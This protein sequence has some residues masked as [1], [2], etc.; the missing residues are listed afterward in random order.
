VMPTEFLG[1]PVDSVPVQGSI[2]YVMYG[3]DTQEVLD[4]LS[5]EL[6]THVGEGRKLIEGTLDLSRLIAHV[7]DYEDDFSWIKLTVDLSGTEQHI[8]DPLSPTGA[9]F[10]K[11]VRANIKG[12]HKDEAERIVNN[13][14]EVKKAEVSVWPPWTRMLPSIPSSIIIEPVYE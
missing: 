7:I 14:P 12:V 3:Y 4:M 5:R 8:L 13:Y 10:A 9:V 11:K 6:H 1:K 2:V